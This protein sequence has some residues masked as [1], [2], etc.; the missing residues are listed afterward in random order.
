MIAQD[1]IM[2]ISSTAKLGGAAFFAGFVTALVAAIVV[3][4]RRHTSPGG[5]DD[6]SDELQDMLGI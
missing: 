1:E 4:K 6:V 5:A 3:T 2:K